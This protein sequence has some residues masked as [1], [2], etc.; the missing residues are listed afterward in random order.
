MVSCAYSKSYG[1][2]KFRA[3]K[4]SKSS[5]RDEFPPRRANRRPYDCRREIC[6]TGIAL[7][8]E[9]LRRLGG[10]RHR[11]GGADRN[12]QSRLRITATGRRITEWDEEEDV[13]G[14]V[15][16]FVGGVGQRDE[17]HT[18]PLRMTG[19]ANPRRADR[20]HQGNP[21]D[22]QGNAEFWMLSAECGRSTAQGCRAAGNG[23][24]R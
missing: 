11:S 13:C 19:E 3:G 1:R 20:P 2:R 16:K 14:Y 23:S 8:A 24:G 22:P 5:Q 17:M 15:T 12:E 9:Q 7:R 21:P 18:M 4:G 6:G 10:Q